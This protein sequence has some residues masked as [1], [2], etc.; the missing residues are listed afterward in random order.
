MII[1]IMI[2]MIIHIIVYVSVLYHGPGPDGREDGAKAHR[3][4]DVVAP[5]YVI[6]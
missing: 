5:G 1:I 4:R 2:I 3:V 6:S